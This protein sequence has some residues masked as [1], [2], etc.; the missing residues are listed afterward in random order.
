MGKTF[1]TQLL[2]NITHAIEGDISTN[3]TSV[4][5]GCAAKLSRG[6]TNFLTSNVPV[7][8]HLQVDPT[9]NPSMNLQS[10]DKG[11]VQNHD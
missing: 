5:I 4:T 6:K 2:G 9:N 3:M 1:I 7:G 11:N 8:E 10:T